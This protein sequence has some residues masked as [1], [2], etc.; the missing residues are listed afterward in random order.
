MFR[1]L[2]LAAVLLIPA[3]AFAQEEGD[4]PL[5]KT[6]REVV[7]ADPN[8][9]KAWDNYWSEQYQIIQ[10][11]IDA[12]PKSAEKTL[13]DVEALVAAHPPTNDVAIK[14]VD[15][16]KGTFASLHKALAFNQIPF[17]DIEQQLIANPDDPKAVINYQRKLSTELFPLAMSDV[18]KA[19]E[20]LKAVKATLEK[21]KESAKQEASK[22]AIDN[23]VKSLAAIDQ[24]I[25]AGREQSDL[26]GQPAAP[27][28]IDAWVNGKPLSEEELKGKVIILDFWAVW[29]GPCIATFPHLREW[30]EKYSDKGLVIIGVTKNYNFAWDE[31]SKKPMKSDE[32]VS[33]EAEAEMLVKFA[34]SHQLKHRFA[35]Q[36][37]N[38]LNEFY[39][40]RGIPQIVVIDQQNKVQ[41][42]KVGSG[43]PNAKA[44]DEVLK[45]LFA[46]KS[47]EDKPAEK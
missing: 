11:L 12:D 26:V 18:K 23:V 10:F 35:V 34:E 16:M 8:N 22:A 41:L 45:K 36:E 20:Q 38:E 19:A 21:V 6:P 1:A 42:I 2:S 7:A 27:L 32:D 46:E 39:R 29:C 43:E 17:A 31:A 13:A 24:A 5:G 15:R 47:A 44:V 3:F 9:T 33:P 14:H 40:V 37:N 28:H 25:I 30:H 4:A